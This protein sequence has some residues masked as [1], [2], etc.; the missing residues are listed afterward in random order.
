MVGTLKEVMAEMITLHKYMRGDELYLVIPWTSTDIELQADNEGFT[1]T[2][3]EILQVM[4]DIDNNHDANLGIN[5][6]TI[7]EVI[8]NI[9][10]E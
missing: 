8:R 4:M 3:E 6:E 7:S 9:K 5:W 1:L 2:D 10:G